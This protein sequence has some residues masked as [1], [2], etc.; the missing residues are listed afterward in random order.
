MHIVNTKT[1]D[2]FSIKDYKEKL[3]QF[4]EQYKKEI[5]DNDLLRKYK[6]TTY[7][8]MKVANKAD[9]LIT[10]LAAS[11]DLWTGI[12]ATNAINEIIDVSDKLKQWYISES[13][14]G[15]KILED[16]MLRR[17]SGRLHSSKIYSETISIIKEMLAEEGLSGKYDSLLKVENCFPESF[18]YQMI[19]YPEN[20]HLINPATNNNQTYSL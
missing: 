10:G 2:S 14:Q 15:T 4:Y 13:S 16:F 8:S 20:V 12:V 18:F 5:S 17:S 19:G 3:N 6:E 7:D 9:G 1:F 11:A